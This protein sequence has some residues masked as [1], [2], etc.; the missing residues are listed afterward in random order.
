MRK[1]F[2]IP[3]L[4]RQRHRGKTIWNQ[5]ME[6]CVDAKLCLKLCCKTTGCCWFAM[7][8]LWTFYILPCRPTFTRPNMNSSHLLTL[9]L[10]SLSF[11]WAL[12]QSL[13]I[14]RPAQYYWFVWTRNIPKTLWLIIMFPL[15]L[16]FADFQLHTYYPIATIHYLLITTMFG[17]KTKKNL[18]LCAG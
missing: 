7:P 16:L 18:F 4:Y 13:L 8:S 11:G 12:Q 17:K 10:A 1:W 2:R 6:W 15:T 9:R 14:L 3:R 5:S